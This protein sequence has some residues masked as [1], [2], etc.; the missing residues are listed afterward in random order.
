MSKCKRPRESNGSWAYLCVASSRAYQIFHERGY[1]RMI[2]PASKHILVVFLLLVSSLLILSVF[3]VANIHN[4]THLKS[5]LQKAQTELARARMETVRAQ[6]GLETVPEIKSP[7]EPEAAGSESTTSGDTLSATEILAGTHVIAHGMGAVESW[8]EGNAPLNCLE[9]FLA[10]YA[11]GVRV[12]EADLRLTRDGKVVLRHDWWPT[13][14]QEGINGARIP[15]REE[16]LSKPILGEY[17][18][19]SF[20]DLLIL[21]EKYP[22]VCIITDTKFTD[23]DIIF[24]EFDSMLADARELGL[25]DMFDRIVIQLYN[26]V[27][28]QCLENIYPFPHRIHTLY[29]QGFDQTVDAFREIAAYC[30][31]NGVEG[32]AMWDSWWDSAYAPIAQEYGI[33]VYVH[34]VNDGLAA[35]TLLESG[36]NGIYTDILTPSEVD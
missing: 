12:F 36:V 6:A 33:A 31:E 13:D 32:I 8:S 22:D 21:L 7:L 34:T 19:L 9:G 29:V 18:P 11:K 14:W 4:I 1:L 2:K 30:S 5:E 20:R 15:T 27:M 3:I 16:F 35:R 25:A 28:R 10:Q 26:G 24:I 17:T 23:S